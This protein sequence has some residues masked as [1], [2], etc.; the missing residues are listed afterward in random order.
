MKT[1]SRAS[2]I[3]RLKSRFN[4]QKLPFDYRGMVK[5]DYARCEDERV[6]FDLWRYGEIESSGH[7]EHKWRYASDEELRAIIKEEL[8]DGYLKFGGN[9]DQWEDR[10]IREQLGLPKRISASGLKIL[11]SNGRN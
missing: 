1:H 2:L 10:Q 8:D 6:Y 4:K 3:E 9:D 5:E 7:Q 11:L